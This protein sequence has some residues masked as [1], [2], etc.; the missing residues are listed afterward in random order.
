MNKRIFTLVLCL[1]LLPAQ[2]WCAAE[3]LSADKFRLVAAV[4][5]DL[6]KPQETLLVMDD[7]D[8]LT[9]MPCSDSKDTDKCQYL[10]GPAWSSWQQTLIGTPS[11]YRVASSDDEL[12]AIGSALF[13]VNFM[14]YTE[15]D[16]PLVLQELTNTGVRLLVETARGGGDISATENQLTYLQVN[17]ADPQPLLALIAANTLIMPEGQPSLASPFMPCADS[18]VRPVSYRQGVMYVAGQNKG[19]MLQCLLSK[20][21]T[22]RPIRNILFIDDTLENVKDVYAAFKNSTQYNVKAIHYTHLQ[23]HKEALT[24]GPMSAVYQKKANE[25]WQAL[26]T[27]LGKTMQKPSVQ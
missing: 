16:L 8:T 5:S 20:A 2:A 4:I 1:A 6:G 23:K 17:S 15:A 18:N 21:N 13:A 12:F 27:V 9:M 25:R 19:A 14:D 11:P 3:M 24:A 26:K 22:E 10:G 7:D